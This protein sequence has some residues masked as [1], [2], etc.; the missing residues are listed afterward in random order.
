M[1]DQN[2]EL[3][4]LDGMW[5]RQEHLLNLAMGVGNY[6]QA[7]HYLFALLADAVIKGR[8]EAI[9]EVNKVREHYG[10][11]AIPLGQDDLQE[12]DDLQGKT[13]LTAAD[14]QAKRLFMKMKEEERLE[15]LRKCMRRLIAD[16][17]LF[18]YARH[19]LAIFLVVRDRLM[20]ESLNQ[21]NFLTLANE[22]TP[23]SLP[24]KLR[25]GENTRKNLGREI[26]EADRGEV[27]YR[28]KRNPQ[29]QLCDTFWDIVKDTILT[30]D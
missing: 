23:E 18:I 24:L 27:Y 16:Y 10:V 11:K 2:K 3:L 13:R 15:V 5:L 29:K 26:C 30:Q 20:G 14:E 7:E 21:T 17:H 12:D 19:W 28:M 1:K 9:V 6:A 22:I 4:Y 8:C 25:F